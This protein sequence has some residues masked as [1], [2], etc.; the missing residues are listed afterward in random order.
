ME[1]PVEPN[2]GPHPEYPSTLTVLDRLQQHVN[3]TPQAVALVL[4]EGE[5]TQGARLEL[6]YSSMW[7]SIEDTAMQLRRAG[8]N[9][10]WINVVLPSGL[11]QVI[12]VWAILRAG[13]GYVPIDS[14]TEAPR[15]RTLFE[16]TQPAAAIGLPGATAL[17]TV[18]AEF[19]VI[20]CSFPGGIAAGLTTS[21]HVG[22]HA[23]LPLVKVQDTALL[24]F[25]SGSTGVPKGIVYD[26]KCNT[27][28]ASPLLERMV[29]TGLFG[30]SHFVGLD[31]QL[32]RSSNCLLRCS[33]VWSVSLYDLFPA[34]L[35]G[36]T[37]FIPPDGGH[38]NVQYMAVSG[39]RH[40]SGG[41]DCKMQL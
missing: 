21:S 12:T 11:A 22:P 14:Q 41:W 17:S 31:M 36:G 35:M 2:H 4:P 13:C 25:S 28:L 8:V 37:L 32:N 29:V 7:S 34:N 40:D 3:D 30:G 27:Q 10:G 26:H 33:Y 23:Q 20:H 24:L 9:S 39:D 15:L 38:R 1:S 19:G 16:Q 6:S 5:F 18:A